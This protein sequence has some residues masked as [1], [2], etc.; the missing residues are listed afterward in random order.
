VKGTSP[1]LLLCLPY[2]KFAAPMQGLPGMIPLQCAVC[3]CR[4][5]LIMFDTYHKHP[6]CFAGGSANPDGVLRSY[7]LAAQHNSKPLDPRLV[8]LSQQSHHQQQQRAR[9]MQHVSS[10]PRQHDPP[11]ASPALAAVN[12]DSVA[13]GQA[14]GEEEV[15]ETGQHVNGVLPGANTSSASSSCKPCIIA[16]ASSELYL[17][18]LP[19]FG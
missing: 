15:G 2:Y 6:C 12:V 7:P 4:S 3:T 19:S 10:D 1:C 8:R 5:C 11:A 9:S 17:T 16:I 13:Q 14:A 18:A